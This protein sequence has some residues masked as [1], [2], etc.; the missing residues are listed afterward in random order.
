MF[1]TQ[2]RNTKIGEY[3]KRTADARGVYVRGEYVKQRKSFA[4][5]AFDDISKVIHIKAD[6]WIFVGF[7]F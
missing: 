2:I 3:I 5:Y 4:C 7:D 1:A 6:K